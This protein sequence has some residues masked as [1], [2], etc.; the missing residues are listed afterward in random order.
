MGGSNEEE[1]KMIKKNE[2]WEL[3]HK[4]KDKEVIRQKCVYKIKYNED[5]SMHE[6]KAILVAKR[7]FQQPGINYSKT[8]SPVVYMETIRVVLGV[9]A[10]LKFQVYQL[11]VKSAFLDRELEEEAYVEKPQGY[12][13]QGK[14]DM[15]YKLK[16]GIIWTKVSTSGMESQD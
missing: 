16:E 14:E 6:S 15:V 10:R 2:T 5:G 7:Y 9:A 12:I 1:I 4:L 3:V 8:F 11:D 13:I